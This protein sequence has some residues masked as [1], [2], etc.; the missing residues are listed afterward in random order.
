MFS[1]ARAIR[2]FAN[3]RVHGLAC[4]SLSQDASLAGSDVT[5]RGER[6]VS[7]QG[8]RWSKK[9]IKPQIVLEIAQF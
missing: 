1:R 8:R 5:I 7:S 6:V 9:P 4:V 3:D 2:P